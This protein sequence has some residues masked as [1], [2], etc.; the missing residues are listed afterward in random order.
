MAACE[1]CWGDAYMRYLS[2]PDKSQSEHYI[3]LIK[4]RKYIGGHIHI[5][6][7]LVKEKD[8]QISELEKEIIR[9]GGKL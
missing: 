3:E 5:L 8:H 2:N 9:L 4:E 6:Q 1:T 7:E